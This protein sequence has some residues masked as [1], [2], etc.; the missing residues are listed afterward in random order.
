MTLRTLSA[1]TFRT[2]SA[3][4]DI[5]HRA[6]RARCPADR[7]ARRGCRHRRRGPRRGARGCRRPG[8]RPSSQ[9]DQSPS[10]VRLR[11]QGH[12]RRPLQL[13]GPAARRCRP[14]LL[15]PGPDPDGLRLRPVVRQGHHGCRSDD[16]HR[17]R[18]P[19]P[20]RGRGPR[21]LRRDVRAAGSG[22]RP[23]RAPG[24]HAVRRQQRRAGRLVRRDRA[25]RPVGTR[26]GARGE[27]R[28]R[29][30]QVERRHRHLQRD[31][32]GDRPQRRRRDLAE[33]R[34]SGELLRSGARQ[35]AARPVRG[36][37]VEGHHPRRLVR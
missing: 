24:S 10:I 15:H 26:G 2:R 4:D 25:R 6:S 23:V 16:R 3:R 22:L 12:G 19:E 36:R 29:P 32:V 17:R 11:R 20:G 35:E 30:R 33:L 5:Q 31:E 1:P 7:R 27:D 37:D 8:G 14:A 18:V 21:D 13:S 28:P 9:R 34:R